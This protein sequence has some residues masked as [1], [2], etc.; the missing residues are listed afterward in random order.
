M[1]KK[2]DYV[3]SPRDDRD[4]VLKASQDVAAN[5]SNA[6]MISEN[7]NLGAFKLP[8]NRMESQG[9]LGSCT[10]FGVT[11]AYER[12]VSVLTKVDSFQA[13][14]MFNYSNSRILD[15]ET[16]DVDE[17][18]TLRSACGNLRLLGICRDTTWPYT[19]ANASVTPSSEAYEEARRLA[20]TINYFEVRRTLE[21][22]KMII[23]G[24]G[25][26]VT[27]GFLVYPG[28]ESQAARTTG[29]VPDPGTGDSAIGGHC[30]NL[31]GWDDTTRRFSFIN[32]YGETYGQKG[33]GTISYDY[34]LNNALTP[35]VKVLLPTSDFVN[36][37]DDFM[38][39]ASKKKKPDDS[40]LQIFVVLLIVTL[41]MAGIVYYYL[42]S[43]RSR[44]NHG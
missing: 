19:F 39:D 26:Y 21:V 25:Y 4:Y 20:Q 11:T 5:V 12:L 44:P 9:A 33:T 3:V 2:Y 34:I 32:Q 18:T 28:F 1:S 27:I 23:G 8:V 31:Y 7:Y 35:E 43:R 10:G 16:L 29:D 15:A 22:L 40:L 17:G 24:Y 13:S 37:I 6:S 38:F 42:R 41:L 14:P 36:K 30:V